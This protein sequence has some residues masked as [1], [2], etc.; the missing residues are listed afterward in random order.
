MTDV[1]PEV[2]AE[3]VVVAP[4]EDTRSF[5]HKTLDEIKA[6]CLEG[7]TETEHLVH[8]DQLEAAYAAFSVV[9]NPA[10]EGVTQIEAHVAVDSTVAPT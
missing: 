7:E 4:V 10:P 1:V 2:P 6:L 5:I 3:P 8:K 9:S